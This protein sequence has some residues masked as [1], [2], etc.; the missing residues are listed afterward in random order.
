MDSSVGIDDRSS[1]LPSTETPGA[2]PRSVDLW[3]PR[4]VGWASV[5]LAFPTG[6][7]LAAANSWRL[8]R[9]VGSIALVALGAVGVLAI[10]FAPD[11]RAPGLAVGIVVGILLYGLTRSDERRL[12]NVGIRIER[13]PLRVGGAAIVAV[14]LLVFAPVVALEFL[15]GQVEARLGGT[16]EFGT[17]VADCSVSGAT[18]AF[19]AV[20]PIFVVAH[21]R[22]E[23][24]VGEV[25]EATVSTS[26]GVRASTS[27]T[28][29]RPA[30]CITGSLRAGLAGDGAYRVQYRVGAE[31]L[32]EGTFTIGASGRE[33]PAA[34]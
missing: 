19:S 28:I 14:W 29:D 3:S 25:V 9:P 31:V 13:P 33:S 22:R 30:D 4:T 1:D 12:T 27:L 5:L 34:S 32:A 20:Q 24:R 21:L 23:V 26:D 10:G 17:G 18:A 11:G 8:H 6:I 15:G 7:A 16:V 2:E